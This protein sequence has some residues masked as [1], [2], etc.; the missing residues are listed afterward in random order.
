M[1]SNLAG[2]REEEE[3][4]TEGNS[5]DTEDTEEERRGKGEWVVVRQIIVEQDES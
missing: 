4:T 3:F 2:K 5:E 1:N